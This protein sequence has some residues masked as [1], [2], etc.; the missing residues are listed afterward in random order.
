[1]AQAQDLSDV[2]NPKYVPLTTEEHDLFLEKQKFMYAVLETKVE[3][4]KGKSIIQQYESMYDAQKLYEKWNNNTIVRPILQC[5]LL[6]GLWSKRYLT[7]VRT[8][9]GSW[10]GS[11][12][13][14]IINWQ[15]Q[16]RRYKQLVPT[17]SN[18]RDEQKIAMLQVTV[19]PLR[20]LLKEHGFCN[21]PW[22]SMHGLLRDLPGTVEIV[23]I[24]LSSVK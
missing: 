13:N 24:C 9:D 3:N 7:T 20:E 15:E 5:L 1:M 18:Y 14:F 12:E 22:L 11:L 16:F 10:H 17:A 8:D 19:H 23:L 4:A 2:L 21:I 6:I